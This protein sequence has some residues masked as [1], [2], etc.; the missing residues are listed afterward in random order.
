[1]IILDTNVLSEMMRPTPN[2]KVLARLE[3]FAFETV[4]TTSITIQELYFG[5]TLVRA[6]DRY[7]A[8]TQRIADLHKI[9][10]AGRV[11]DYDAV[12]A[13]I[14]G[15]LQA[16]QKMRGEMIDY[17]DHQIA[18]IAISKKFSVATRN[19]KDFQHAGVQVFNP[20]EQS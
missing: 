17:G 2:M 8:L 4:F 14:G 11:L 6:T 1:M 13:Q 18:A 9:K 12:A 15:R 5:A 3:Q 20:W 19:S 10:F 16:E 7:E